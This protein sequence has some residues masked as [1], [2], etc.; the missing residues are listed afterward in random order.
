MYAIVVV[1]ETGKIVTVKPLPSNSGFLVCSLDAATKLV[2]WATA[3]KT[4]CGRCGLLARTSELV[5]GECGPTVGCGQDPVIREMLELNGA[6]RDIK[7][8]QLLD[9]ALDKLVEARARKAAAQE[10][11]AT[12]PEAAASP[13]PEPE[14]PSHSLEDW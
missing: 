9:S 10:L 14:A 7:L 3:S 6:G 4:M 8:F 1:D 11:S 5:E 12:T 2:D 13:P